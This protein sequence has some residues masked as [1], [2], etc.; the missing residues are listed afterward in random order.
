MAKQLVNPNELEKILDFLFDKMIENGMLPPQMKNDKN[1]IISSVM[2]NFKNSNVE[3]ELTNLRD[4]NTQKALCLSIVSETVNTLTQD[5]NPEMKFDY[6][7]LFKPIDSEDLKEQLKLDLKKALTAIHN[8]LEKKNPHPRPVPNFA[9]DID[10]LAEKL[11]YDFNVHGQSVN[12]NNNADSKNTLNVYEEMQWASLYALLGYSPSG[13]TPSVT[14]AGT[15]ANLNGYAN[16]EKPNELSFMGQ[17]QEKQFED[18]GQ[19][20]YKSTTIID[21]MMKGLTDLLEKEHIL[22]NPH[23]KPTPYE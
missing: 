9:K 6:T 11:A 16:I 14:I 22:V 8:E 12:L 18:L 23:P 10:K 3:I 17:E 19:S 13:K 1:Q 20:G 2:D 21:D 5:K 15:V 7:K 4:P